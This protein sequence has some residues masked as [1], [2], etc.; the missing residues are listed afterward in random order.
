MK[1]TNVKLAEV[2]K[3]A[4]THKNIAD[5]IAAHLTNTLDVRDDALNGLDLTQAKNILD[6]GC[7][8]GFFTKALHGRVHP[9]A[10]ITGIDCHPQY[11]TLY[12]NA[13]NEVGINGKFD[14]AGVSIINQFDSNAFDLILCSYALYYFPGYISEI[15]RILKKD[16]IFVAVTHS[17]PHMREFTSYV[18]NILLKNKIHTYGDLPYE[19]LI[20]K[21]TNENATRLLYPWFHDV[22]SKDYISLLVFEKENFSDFVQYF[23]FKHPFFIPGDQHDDEKL[24]KI[25]LETLK[26]DIEVNKTLKITKD[27][28]IY[29]CSGPINTKET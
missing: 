26:K 15:S 10:K 9:E 18:R 20:E 25:I 1:N 2:F 29:I 16:G 14:S 13:C 5:I 23:R 28:V 21:F 11:E 22:L 8:F 12:L 27:D 6:L 4:L 17:K 24:T 7:G 19:A 3:D